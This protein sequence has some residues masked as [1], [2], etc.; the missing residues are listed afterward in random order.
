MYS[1]FGICYASLGKLLKQS[2]LPKHH[3]IGNIFLSDGIEVDL[4]SYIE[5]IT[6][7]MTYLNKKKSVQA[8]ACLRKLSSLSL[9]KQV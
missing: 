6:N 7:E 1:C 2:Y 4:M 5:R 8:L 3:N 9:I